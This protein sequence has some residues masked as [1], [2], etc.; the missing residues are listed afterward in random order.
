M[1]YWRGA[2]ID[3]RR[4]II[5]NRRNAIRAFFGG[6][7]VVPL[8]VLGGKPERENKLITISVAD[9]R[10]VERAAKYRFKGSSVKDWEKDN[11]T[12]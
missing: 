2:Y 8:A 5:I 9:K 10:I 6:L 12:R 7:A 1:P 4:T 11:A 3:H